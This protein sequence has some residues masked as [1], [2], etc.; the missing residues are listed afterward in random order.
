MVTIR[1]EIF[2]LVKQ[3][4]SGVDNNSYVTAEYVL[5]PPSFP[6]IVVQE[7]NNIPFKRATDLSHHENLTR[8]EFE[9][10]IYTDGQ[11]KISANKEMCEAIDMALNNIGF[12]R[13]YYSNIPN[14]LNPTIWRS[15]VRYEK[16]I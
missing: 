11:G 4:A 14:A 7:I 10:D 16:I 2:T 5:Q 8:C 6:C 3:T 13:T 9:I 12:Q 1:N 15:V